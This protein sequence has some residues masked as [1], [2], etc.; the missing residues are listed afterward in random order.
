MTGLRVL[1]PQLVSFTRIGPWLTLDGPE[2]RHS[3]IRALPSRYLCQSP[4]L[5]NKTTSSCRK[6]T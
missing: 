5:T 1:N 2:T 4:D 6:W 3:K